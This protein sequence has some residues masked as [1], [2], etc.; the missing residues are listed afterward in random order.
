MGHCDRDFAFFENFFAKFAKK[1]EKAVVSDESYD[2]NSIKIIHTDSMENAV[3]IARENAVSGDVISLS[4]AS[5]SFDKYKDF[6]ERGR[7]FKNIVK[8]LV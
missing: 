5:A 8:D 7:H 3:K 2:E 6:E 4:P 1:I